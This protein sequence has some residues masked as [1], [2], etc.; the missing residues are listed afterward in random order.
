MALSSSQTRLNKFIHFSINLVFF[1][2]SS[3]RSSKENLKC[4]KKFRRKT[5]HKIQKYKF[6]PIM[7]QHFERFCFFF[8]IFY[9]CWDCE[10]LKVI[11]FKRKQNEKKFN[12]PI[13]KFKQNLFMDVRVVCVYILSWRSWF[14]ERKAFFVSFVS[15]S[16]NWFS[17]VSNFD[18]C[19]IG[20]CCTVTRL[21]IFL[22][23]IKLFSNSLVE[24]FSSVDFIL[25][26]SYLIDNL[27]NW[28]H[29]SEHFKATKI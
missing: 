15:F 4:C 8:V 22:I 25:K 20:F 19:I 6:D 14:E 26:I 18:C 17:F 9:L 2:S 28:R 16:I 23:F 1:L 27:L 21:F 7:R 10:K 5:L 3:K 24:D 13:C 12:K 29:Y 11:G